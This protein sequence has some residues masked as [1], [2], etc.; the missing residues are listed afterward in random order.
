M[1][2][3]YK[4]LEEI[5]RNLEKYANIGDTRAFQD[6]TARFQ[7]KLPVLRRFTWMGKEAEEMVER[8]Q[9]QYVQLQARLRWNKQQTEGVDLSHL[10]KEGKD[11]R[12]D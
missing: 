3:L 10:F 12:L 11:A 6:E 7:A 4:P 5:M 8:Y 2:L 9:N 1:T